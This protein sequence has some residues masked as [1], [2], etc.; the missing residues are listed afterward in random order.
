MYSLCIL[1]FANIIAKSVFV[2]SGSVDSLSAKDI[3][4]LLMAAT[5]LMIVIMLTTL[6]TLTI[7]TLTTLTTLM[8]LTALTM[9]T[10]LTTLTTAQ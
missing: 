1:N 7:T 10:L 6:M 4:I 8:T 2:T 3:E 9:L 5:S